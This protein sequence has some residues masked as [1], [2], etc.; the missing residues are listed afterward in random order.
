MNFIGACLLFHSNDVIAFHLFDY[1]LNELRLKDVYG[2]DLEGLYRHCKI[3]EALM[4]EK[5]NRLYLHLKRFD[6]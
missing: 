5:L 6:I 1:L 2:K 4:Q 3:I